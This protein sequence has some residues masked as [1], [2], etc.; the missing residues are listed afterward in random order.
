MLLLF[1]M[2]LHRIVISIFFMF[3]F[4]LLRGLLCALIL[5]TFSDWWIVI[6]CF[7]VCRY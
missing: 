6:V 1:I 5:F 7:V 3:D 4:V 2:H